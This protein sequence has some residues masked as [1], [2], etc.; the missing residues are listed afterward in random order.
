MRRNPLR[1]YGAGLPA[2]YWFLW[3]GTLVNRLGTFLLPFLALYLTGA[4]GLS[5]ATATLVVAGYGAGAFASNFLGG[6]L[7]DRA[8]RRA[9]LLL[10]LCAGA[11]TILAVPW[12]GPLPALAA[13]LVVA[14]LATDMSRPA[15][16]AA[17]ADLVDDADRPRAYALLYW[18]ANLGMAVGPALGGLLAARSFVALFTA[19]AATMLV[20]AGLVAWRVPETKPAAAAADADAPPAAARG[21][22]RTAL[23]DP[24]LVGI[25]LL[26]LLVACQ[27][28]QAFSVLPLAMRASGVNTAGFG[29][30][31]S[32]NGLLVVL[33]SLPVALWVS[34]R[35]RL[36]AMAA[37]SLLI[38][39]GMALNAAAD[40]L[41][42][43][44]VAVAVWTLGE[45]AFAP[46]AP[47]LV[48]ELAPPR[49]R[50]GYH[51]VYTASWGLAAFLGPAVG[52]QVF[53]RLG[54]AA[55]WLGCLAAAVA[56]A[57]GFLTLAPA[58]R[59]RG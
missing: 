44:L 14:G 53:Q 46:V 15:V 41:P 18:A 17:V 11:T 39:C 59:R 34:R 55:L 38:G 54:P 10:G 56:A 31:L 20:Y 47:A 24:L 22:L 35:P 45:V 21:H 29:L 8:G 51:G 57:A 36:P 6:W 13:V 52:G 37:A 30:A 43:Y 33:F 25:T 50:G 3:T 16:A 19:D 12:I 2:T 32:L 48:A 1:A 4:R 28:V 42:A 49:A 5:A 58:A 23:S 40:A 7:A 26:S 27:F 9:T